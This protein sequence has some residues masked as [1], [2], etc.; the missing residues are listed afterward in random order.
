MHH[1][2]HTWVAF[3]DP[4]EWLLPLHTQCLPS[5]MQRY[6]N[7]SSLAVQR[8]AAAAAAAASQSQ[9]PR[10]AAGLTVFEAVN[11]TLGA[12]QPL[13]RPVCHSQ[14]AQGPTWG[15]P[16]CCDSKPGYHRVDERNTVRRHATD[17]PCWM[18]GSDH[19]APGQ[20][21]AHIAILHVPSAT[22]AEHMRLMQ[23]KSGGGTGAA[24]SAAGIQL[25]ESVVTRMQGLRELLS[26]VLIGWAQT[27]REQGIA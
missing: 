21:P 25:H 26:R 18:P 1:T 15:V 14:H 3:L 13:V 19:M 11:F 27:V 23:Q 8:Y 10:Q 16:H 2:E 9:Q 17:T 4:D 5:L 24:G 12:P 22:P 7:A 20:G 6:A